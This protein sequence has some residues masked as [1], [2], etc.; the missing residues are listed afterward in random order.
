MLKQILLGAP[1][2]IIVGTVYLIY[3][4]ISTKNNWTTN[5]NTDAEKIKERT[6]NRGMFVSIISAIILSVVGAIMAALKV[7]ENMIV[8]NYGFILGP[9]IGYMLDIGIGTDDGFRQFNK[10]KGEWIKYIFASLIDT[11]FLRY[12]ITVL[13]DLF[14]SDPIQDILREQINPIREEM[15]SG[16]IY[17]SMLGSNLP[18]IIQGIVGFITF[19]AYTNQTRFNWAYPS[20][21][22]ADKD[23]M[24]TFL[25]S[26]STAIAGALYIV[27]NKGAEDRSIKVSY[28]I[29]AIS[30][31]Y[32]MNSFGLDKDKS[33]K[34]NEDE[35][36]DVEVKSTKYR[37]LV[38]VIVFTLFVLY[39]LAWPLMNTEK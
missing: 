10:N 7:P 25:I 35:S 21:N 27:H 30:M 22:L 5:E 8:I 15:T 24:S 29:A 6:T 23:K 4:L 1:P 3:S 11:K 12:T 13:L 36:E 39:G 34:K 18:S 32:I 37:Y 31:L 16:G 38:G 9:V 17:S 33:D 19:N 28:V 26:L 14:I 20:E 2:V